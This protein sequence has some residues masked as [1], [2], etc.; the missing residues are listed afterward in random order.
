M[1]VGNLLCRGKTLGVVGFGDIGQAAARIARAFGMRIAALRRRAELSTQEQADGLQ[2]RP[3][4][5]HAA[6]LLSHVPP[7][8]SAALRRGG[9]AC[10]EAAGVRPVLHSTSL[11]S[12]CPCMCSCSPAGNGM[13]LIC[14][15]QAPGQSCSAMLQ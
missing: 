2:V 11:L 1:L 3:P 7:S 13:C 15:C 14:R 12:P 4:V 6:S 8:C 5:L 9:A 10:A